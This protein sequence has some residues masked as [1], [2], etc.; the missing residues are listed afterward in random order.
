MCSLPIKAFYSDELI[1]RLGSKEAVVK[2]LETVI[3][4]AQSFFYDP[5]LPV[6]FGLSVDIIYKANVT[7]DWKADYDTFDAISFNNE[8]DFAE[9]VESHVVFADDDY[10]PDGTKG[11]GF[12]GSICGFWLDQKLAIVEYWGHDFDGAWVSFR[13][14]I[15]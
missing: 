3:A 6:T 10:N 13:N 11:I 12:I 1:N 7:R 15:N 4:I 5:S 2:K 9:N 8:I 14:F